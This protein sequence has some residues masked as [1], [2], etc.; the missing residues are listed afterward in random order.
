MEQDLLAAAW[1]LPVA[2]IYRDTR[3][4]WQKPRALCGPT[5]IAN[6]LRS[7]GTEVDRDTLLDGTGLSTLF[8]YRL[9]GMTLDQ[10]AEVV[11]AKSTRRATVLRDLDLGAFIE[12][13]RLANDP[14]RRYIVNFSRHG[15]GGHGGGH[16]SPI[17]GYLED[18]DRALV[19]D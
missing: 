9:A 7:F 6:A 13:L 19:L 2:A 14:A 10:L 8:G 5:S 15:A 3:L 11:R 1:R 17:A 12:H 16:H 4:E 18:A